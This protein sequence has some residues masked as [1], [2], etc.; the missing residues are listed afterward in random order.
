M[1]GKDSVGANIPD[2]H[3]E[4]VNPHS[5]ICH[6]SKP[7]KRPDLADNH[8]RGHEDHKTDDEAKVP[9]GNLR[10]GLS[11]AENKSSHHKNHLNEL[12]NVD[13]MTSP[14]AV[15]TIEHVA[16]VQERIAI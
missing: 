9:L 5:E 16:K 10:D 7:L 6:P 8:A 2:E 11:V 1:V 14:F 3:D 15:D 13:G 4:N 12:G